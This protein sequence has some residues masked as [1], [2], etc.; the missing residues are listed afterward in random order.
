MTPESCLLIQRFS[1]ELRTLY[2][3]LYCYEDRHLKGD[4]ST[5]WL[6]VALGL[7]KSFYLGELTSGDIKGLQQ[8]RKGLQN[9]TQQ[10]GN[11]VHRSWQEMFFITSLVVW[12]LLEVGCVHVWD[13]SQDSKW[14]DTQSKVSA[15]HEGPSWIWRKWSYIVWKKSPERLGLR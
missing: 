11:C 6:V 8:C 10:T 9:T 5:L 12:T 3:C 13:V 4:M 2:R 7:D 14:V 1:Q 15:S